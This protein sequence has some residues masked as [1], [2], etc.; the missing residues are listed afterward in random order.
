MEPTRETVNFETVHGHKITVKSYA[1]GGESKE[2]RNILSQGVS[3]GYDEITHEPKLGGFDSK[4]ASLATDKLI[5][6]M[7]ISVDGNTDKILER[8]MDLRDEDCNEV[9]ARLNEIT[10]LLGKKKEEIEE[11]SLSTQKIE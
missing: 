3:M 4:F 1:T 2:V 7:V 6:L 8:V 10:G 9:T 11:K 5:E